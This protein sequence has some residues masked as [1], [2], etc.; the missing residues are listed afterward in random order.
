ME[1]DILKALCV[2]SL[3][4][5]PYIY[6]LFTRKTVIYIGLG[7]LTLVLDPLDHCRLIFPILNVLVCYFKLHMSRL[8][9]FGMQFKSLK[10]QQ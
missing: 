7:P 5:L 1:N 2:E 6:A 3:I 10:K 4:I 8:C 9:E